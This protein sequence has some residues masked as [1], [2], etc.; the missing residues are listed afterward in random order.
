[1]NKELNPYD[2]EGV[3]KEL[4]EHLYKDIALLDTGDKRKASEILTEALLGEINNVSPYDIEA[5][6]KNS[7]GRI[8]L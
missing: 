5:L 3:N 7:K 2:I 6:H 1:M 8:K 4:K